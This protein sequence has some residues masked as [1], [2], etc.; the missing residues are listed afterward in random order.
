MRPLSASFPARHE[1]FSWLPPSYDDRPS[2]RRNQ[3]W[4][5][6]IGDV[7]RPIRSIHG[8][9]RGEAKT[10]QRKADREGLRPGVSQSR[11]GLFYAILNPPCS[12]YGRRVR[13]QVSPIRESVGPDMDPSTFCP[14]LERAMSLGGSPSKPGR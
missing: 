11:A 4:P 12:E 9:A 14:H 3:L 13:F 6:G 8:C 5:C 2:D 1:W 10:A 7:S